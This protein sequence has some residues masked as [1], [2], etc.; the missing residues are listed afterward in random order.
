MSIG[1]TGWT[2]TQCGEEVDGPNDLAH[3][4]PPGTPEPSKNEYVNITG[5]EFDLLTPE[6]T[7]FLPP[8]E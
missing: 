7:F 3:V 1:Y 4:C 2:C 5:T 6:G 8:E